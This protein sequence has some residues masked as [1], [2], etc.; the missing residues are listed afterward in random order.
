LG[1]TPENVRVVGVRPERNDA[2]VRVVSWERHGHAGGARE[3]DWCRERDPQV[4][5]VEGLGLRVEG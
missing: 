2:D 3:P 4:Y 1:F 5:L